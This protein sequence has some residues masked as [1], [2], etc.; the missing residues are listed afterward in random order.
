MGVLTGVWHQCTTFYLLKSSAISLLTQNKLMMSQVCMG[1]LL[2]NV[3]CHWHFLAQMH[4]KK[5]AICRKVYFRKSRTS[6]G[7]FCLLVWTFVLQA[8]EGLRDSFG[9]AH[10]LWLLER[11]Q[12]QNRTTTVNEILTFKW[13]DFTMYNIIYGFIVF[14]FSVCI[15]LCHVTEILKLFM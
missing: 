12:M 1:L 15:R 9:A 7:M 2:V 6:P 3:N 10:L 14:L 13:Q 8:F 4:P 5:K 11:E